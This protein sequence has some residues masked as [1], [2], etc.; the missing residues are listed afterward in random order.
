[1]GNAFREKL[2]SGR[3]LLGTHV[4]LSDFHICEM[5]G[6]L[7]F[8]YLWIDM[9]HL[10]TSFADMETHL[11][12]AKAAGTPT[13]VRIS[14]ND[15]PHTKRVLEAGPDAVVFPMINTVEDAKRAIDTCIY[16][17]EGNR[18]FGPFRAIRYGLDGIDDYIQKGSKAMC[19]FLQVETKDAVMI[20]EETAKIP[21]VDGFIIGPMDL[22]G[23][24]G[25][26]GRTMEGETDRLIDLAIEKAHKAGLPI[27]LSTGA[28]TREELSHWIGKGVDFLSASTDSWSI[29]RGGMELLSLM[30]DI[31]SAHPVFSPPEK[32]GGKL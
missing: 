25:C 27:G 3:R 18:G 5:L 19:R 8:D 1:M 23:S 11:I 12:A 20:M 14:W 31:S 22:S 2:E 13:M 32:G 16:P 7:G 10:S 4:N 28:D 29:L 9:E 17:P 15:V 24:V 21:Y 6:S 30:R 26:L